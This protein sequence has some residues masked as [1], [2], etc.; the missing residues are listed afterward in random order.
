MKLTTA[1]LVTGCGCNPVIA[2]DWLAALQA[3]CEEFDIIV[4]DKDSGKDATSLEGLASFLANIGVES[5]GLQSLEENLNYSA[6][7]LANTFPQRYAVDP[8]VAHKIPNDLAIR[9]QRNPQL[10]ANTTYANRLGNGDVNSGDGWTFRGEG[11]IQLTGRDNFMKF[12][13]A[14]DLPL[15]TDPQTLQ[16]PDNGAKSAAFFFTQLSSAFKLA[17][18]GDFDGSVKA[19]NGQLPCQAN[20]GPLRS[21]RYEAVLAELRKAPAEV[22]QKPPVKV[23]PSKTPAQ[24]SE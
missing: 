14:A 24:K 11:P 22:E 2:G 20:Q 18:Q 1:I 5:N 13:A 16:E 12:F 3:A 4:V 10:I 9:I 6:Q 17:S 8:H 7:G 21:T 23:A 19:V 15:D